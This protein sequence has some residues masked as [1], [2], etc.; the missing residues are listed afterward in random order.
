MQRAMK[1]MLSAGLGA[2]TMYYLDPAQGRERRDIARERLEH[3]R[4]SLQHAGKTAMAVG[5]DVGDRAGRTWYGV[6]AAGHQVG[7]RA[8]RALHRARAVGYD[9]GD[10]AGRL[11][12]GLREAGHDVR[13]RAAGAAS[14][15]ASL[16]ERGRS[17]GHVRRNRTGRSALKFLGIPLTWLFVA[18]IGASAMYFF[19]PSQGLYR[20]V[21]FRDRF[22]RNGREGMHRGTNGAATSE[23][24]Q[25]QQAPRSGDGPG[26]K[27]EARPLPG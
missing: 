13:E 24:E 18:G 2:A 11:T 1:I 14:S 26:P 8:D 7:S 17:R 25:A 9:V 15:L 16:F 12:H 22:L 3:G 20:R 6:R 10:R 4:D 27:E 5:H 19:D 23:D 21:R